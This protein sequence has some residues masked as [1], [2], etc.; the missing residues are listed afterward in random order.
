MLPVQEFNNFISEH[1]LFSIKSKILLAVSG[2]KDSVLMVHLFKEAG[3]NFAIAHCN[4]NLRA[5]EAT[6]DEHFVK[7]LSASLN[8]TFHLTHFDTKKYAGENK[9]STQMAAREL[10]Y[11]WFEEIRAQNGYDY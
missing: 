8:L 1:H 11:Q 6:R 9:I 5:D 10:R 4:F 7:M 3:Y 2:G